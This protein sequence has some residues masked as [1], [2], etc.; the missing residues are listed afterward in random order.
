MADFIRFKKMITPILIQIVFWL[1]VAVAVIGGIVTLTDDVVTG[2]AIIIFGP[3]LLRLYAE[4]LIIV[5]RM[6]ETLTNINDT[7]MDIK[8]DLAQPGS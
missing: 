4:I 6:N 7:V 5:F 3:L 1:G 8:A 2:L